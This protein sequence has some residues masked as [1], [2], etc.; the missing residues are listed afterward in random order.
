MAAEE[1]K[2]THTSPELDFCWEVEP[3]KIEKEIELSVPLPTN[4]QP[5][6]VMHDRG[7]RPVLVN[8]GQAVAV[9]Y[10]LSFDVPREICEHR[11][12]G[13]EQ[14]WTGQL[15]ERG[16][17]RQEL[18]P[19]RLRVVFLSNGEI[20]CYPSYPLPLGI[21]NLAIAADKQSK[22]HKV[23]YTIV[24]DRGHTTKGS[25]LIRFKWVSPGQCAA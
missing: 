16:N 25:L 11:L 6:Q 15:G 1:F 8:S 9:W 10:M 24:T 3:G 4:I 7:I 13:A 2:E 17:W 22:E 5:E 19:D 20:A 18:L 12:R 14:S 23:L 21:L